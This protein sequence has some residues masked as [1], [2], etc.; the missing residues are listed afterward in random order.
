M[1]CQTSRTLSVVLYCLGPILFLLYINDLPDV[2]DDAVMLK[3]FADDKTVLRLAALS[4]NTPT[5][6]DEHLNRVVKWSND[7]QLPISYYKCCIINLGTKNLRVVPC[8]MDT[9]SIPYVDKVVDLGVA[10]DKSLKFSAHVSTICCKANS[11]ANRIHKCFYS[12][13]TSSL[14][15]A[16]KTYVRPIVEYNSVV[17]NPSLIKNITTLEAVQRRFTKRIP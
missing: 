6:I 9:K 10:M 15:S 8:L 3:L 11:R 16:F 13:D 12:K 17:W 4:L 2:F 1:T 7:W 14:L 5:Y